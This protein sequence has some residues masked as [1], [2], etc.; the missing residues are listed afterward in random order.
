MTT[1]TTAA[2][3]IDPGTAGVVAVLNT[4]TVQA[5]VT[6]GPG[7]QQTLWPGAAE[8]VL[9]PRGY[10]VTARTTAGTTTVTVRT[11][12]AAPDL[13]LPGSGGV[14]YDDLAPGVLTGLGTDLIIDGGSP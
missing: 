5:I 1:I 12:V 3:V 2:T 4:G 8:A 11:V 7:D 13:G 9:S 6:G 10:P 14:A